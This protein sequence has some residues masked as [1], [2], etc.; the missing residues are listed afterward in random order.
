MILRSDSDADNSILVVAISTILGIDL[1]DISECTLHRRRRAYHGECDGG[2]V[3][4]LEV[5]L[6]MRQYLLHR[7]RL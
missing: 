1:R 7:I 3:T 2:L 5:V 4:D 6:N